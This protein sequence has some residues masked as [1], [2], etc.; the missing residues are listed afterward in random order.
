MTRWSD[1]TPWERKRQEQ[2]EKVN[3][4]AELIERF[5]AGGLSFRKLADQI[6]SVIH[7]QPERIVRVGKGHTPE[8]QS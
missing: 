7:G 8:V 2:A 1:R 4:L 3:Q 5:K 6:D